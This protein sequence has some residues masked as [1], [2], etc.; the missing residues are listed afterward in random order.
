MQSYL[1]EHGARK[2]EANALVAAPELGRKIMQDEIWCWLDE[3]A[4]RQWED[5][6]ASSVKR[7]KEQARN[8]TAW[9]GMLHSSGLLFTPSAL[10]HG[11]DVV[12]AIKGVLPGGNS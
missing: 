12:T 4:V 8:L 1:A 2:V 5:D 6:N 7:A 3:D 10:L 9:L 11:R